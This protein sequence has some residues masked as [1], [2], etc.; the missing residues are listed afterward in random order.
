MAPRRYLPHAINVLGLR[1]FVF[2]L[3]QDK[4]KSQEKLTLHRISYPRLIPLRLTPSFPY[5]FM[6]K[7][8]N[9]HFGRS[10]D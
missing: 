7:D 2:I 3:N 4:T 5:F 9:L 10:I 6:T 8:R 1:V